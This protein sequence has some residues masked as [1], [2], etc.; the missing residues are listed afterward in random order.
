MILLF[1]IVSDDFADISMNSSFFMKTLLL[2]FPL[3]DHGFRL[4]V[5]CFDVR[6]QEVVNMQEERENLER[7]KLPHREYN[8]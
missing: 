7:D 4:E 1:Q 6:E 3:R 5:L 8:K 2:F